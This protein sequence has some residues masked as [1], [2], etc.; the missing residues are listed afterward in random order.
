MIFS[1][2]GHYQG[3]LAYALERFSLKDNQIY[4]CGE[5]NLTIPSGKK[6]IYEVDLWILALV[7][8]NINVQD[9]IPHF[10]ENNKEAIVICNDISGGIVPVEELLR[11]WREEN[12]RAM[13]VIARQS[14]EVI[15]MFC[16][17]P[18]KLK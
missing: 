16:G 10:I 3:K 9:K 15:R 6:I 11:K 12:G 4:H 14:E 7:K 1:F 13:G 18:S 5:G 2:G 8:E 17:I